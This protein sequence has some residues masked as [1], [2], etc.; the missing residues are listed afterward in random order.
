MLGGRPRRGR[1]GPVGEAA[2]AI[3]A[4]DK[5]ETVRPRVCSRTNSLAGSQK[6][7]LSTLPSVGLSQEEVL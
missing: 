7:L 1:S 5:E 6:D 3:L 2:I 4:G